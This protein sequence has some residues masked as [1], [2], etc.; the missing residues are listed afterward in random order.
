MGKLDPAGTQRDRLVNHAGDA[1][2]I[3]A[4]DDCVDS[5]RNCTPYHFSGESAFA[6]IGAVVASDPVC[7]GGVTVLD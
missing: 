2:D 6:S 4:M 7:R 5:E 3:G 1:V